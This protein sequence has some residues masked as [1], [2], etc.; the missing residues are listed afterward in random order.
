MLI[1]NTNFFIYKLFYINKK[2]LVTSTIFLYTT[3]INN[4]ILV[5][6]GR[7]GFLEWVSH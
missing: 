1:K 2:N 7:G 6:L 5:V 4:I 3:T